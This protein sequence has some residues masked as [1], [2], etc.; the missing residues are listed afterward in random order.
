MDGPK[1]KLVKLDTRNW[2]FSSIQDCFERPPT[3]ISLGH[4]FLK[5]V[6]NQPI[7]QTEAKKTFLM[8]F[9]SSGWGEIGVKSGWNIILHSEYQAIQI[10]ERQYHVPYQSRQNF[11]SRHFF[12]IL[13]RIFMTHFYFSEWVILNESLKNLHLKI[14]QWQPSGKGKM[15]FSI[16]C[17]DAS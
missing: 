4:L 3:F 2:R 9:G 5:I 17:E 1:G 15:L 12:E 16:A 14:V 10:Q 11:S 8:I 13:L 6:S 7:F